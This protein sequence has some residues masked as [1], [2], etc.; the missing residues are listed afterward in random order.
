MFEAGTT[1]DE[2]ICE[3]GVD[4]CKDSISGGNA[5]DSRGSDDEGEYDDKADCEVVS[6]REDE[7]SSVVYDESEFGDDVKGIE[8]IADEV[9]T[10]DEGDSEETAAEVVDVGDGGCDGGTDDMMGSKG[11]NDETK[12]GGKEDSGGT[13]SVEKRSA[14][15][16]ECVEVTDDTGMLSA[17]DGSEVLPK[18]A[19]WEI[20]FVKETVDG[21]VIGGLEPVTEDMSSA[22]FSVCAS[23]VQLCV[24]MGSTSPLISMWVVNGDSGVKTILDVSVADSMF[25]LPSVCPWSGSV[26]PVDKSVSVVPVSWLSVS[27]SRLAGPW[28][29]WEA[30]LIK[31]A[32]WNSADVTS[33]SELVKSLALLSVSFDDI[34]WPKCGAMV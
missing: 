14:G 33:G 13:W 34:G 1:D 3:T 6:N 29:I 31:P 11:N 23:L 19:D 30:L 8:S 18:G 28:V 22:I 24:V 12:A 16:V 9:Y 2:E 25:E 7:V 5:S 20:P 27:S 17:A 10:A 32:A 15:G 26:M 4:D 21:V